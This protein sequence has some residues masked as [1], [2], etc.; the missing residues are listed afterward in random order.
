MT[1]EAP[2]PFD[3]S[4]PKAV[5]ERNRKVKRAKNQQAE[6]L[7]IVLATEQGRRFVWG[8][9]ERCGMFRLSFQPGM[10]ALTGAFNDGGRNVGLPLL[11]ALMNHHPDTYAQMARENQEPTDG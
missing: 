9:L 1:D 5:K 11:A 7:A 6:D 3:A 4:D 2:Q 10:D 8:V